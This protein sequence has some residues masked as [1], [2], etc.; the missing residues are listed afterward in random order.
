MVHTSL[1]HMNM[2]I[3]SLSLLNLFDKIGNW[4]TLIWSMKPLSHDLWDNYPGY[5]IG[6]CHCFKVISHMAEIAYISSF[7]FSILLKDNKIMNAVHLKWS[8]LNFSFPVTLLMQNM[9]IT[10]HS[11][12]LQCKHQPTKCQLFGSSALYQGW[13]VH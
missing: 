3:R 10:F 6:G 1:L 12:L 13:I 11:W 2:L 8:W 9:S 4:S 7:P 5:I